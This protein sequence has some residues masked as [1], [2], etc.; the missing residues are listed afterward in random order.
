[1]PAIRTGLPAESRIWFPLV[2]QN[3][4]PTAV[5]ASGGTT[6]PDPPAETGRAGA[7]AAA[8]AAGFAAAV[9]GA[10]N[11]AVVRAS[12]PAS[13]AAAV[14]SWLGRCLEDVRTFGPPVSPRRVPA[15]G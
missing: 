14:L 9:P 13:A 5:L 12:V 4:A 11:P 3:P 2:C 10:A 1:M 8:G 7:M 15:G 6:P